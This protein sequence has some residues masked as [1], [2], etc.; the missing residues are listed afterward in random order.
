M[1]TMLVTIIENIELVP[2]RCLAFQ[3]SVHKALAERER[4]LH[5][6]YK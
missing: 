5:L 2:A 6:I 4:I 3:L 1:R